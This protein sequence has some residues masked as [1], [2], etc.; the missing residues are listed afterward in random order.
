MLDHF[1]AGATPVHRMDPAAKI[2][3]TLSIVLAASLTGRDRLLPLVPL[4]AAV[5]LYH[6]ISRVPVWYTVKRLLIVSPPAVAVAVLFPFLE[7]GRPLWSTTVGGW[8]VEVTDAGLLRAAGL[9]ARFVVSAWAALLLLSTTRFQDI[10]QAL[11]RLRVPR[12]MVVQLAF[13]YRYLWVMSDESM[14]LRM[15]RAARDGGAG[16]WRL[17]MASRTGIVSVLFLRTYDRAERIYW[18]MTA[19]GFDGTLHGPAPRRM[20]ATD[21]LLAAG[22]IAGAAAV[23]AGDRLIY[24]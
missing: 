21:W 12:A 23:V 11:G 1:A 15:A 2:V 7:A 6:V 10:L 14:R 18:A 16:S 22:A 19:R 5:A 4:F 24:G 17:R 9:C 8:T 13:L 20:R 3:A